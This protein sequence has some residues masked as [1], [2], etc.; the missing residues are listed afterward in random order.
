[1]VI[2]KKTAG[3]LGPLLLLFTASSASAQNVSTY[4]NPAVPTGT[5]VP[6]NY[7]GGLRPQVHF[8]PPQHFMN[9]P[10][11][12]FVDANG[13]WHLYYQYNPTGL[14]AGNQHWGHATSQD[15]YHW[16]N[17]QIALF[18]PEEYV[19]V[20]SGSAVVDVNNTSGFFP[21]QDNGVV[22]MMTLAR[23]YEDGSAGPQVQGI[24]YSHDGGYTFQYY[25]GNPVINSTSSQFRDP[26]VIWYE[27]HW[28][29]VVSYA[30]EFVVGIYTS[31]DLKN[32]TH[33]SNFSHHGLLGAQYECPNLAKLPIRDTIGGS[34][35]S[36]EAYVMAISV[37][38]GAPLG[39]S[40]TQYFPGT[41][42]GTHFEP[43]DSAT[44]L[45]DFAKD[46]YAAQFFYGTP[47]GSDAVS[48]GWASNWQYTQ[49]VPTG[50]L[51]GWRSAATL[52][53]AH[54]L[55]NATRIGWVMASQLVDPSPVL[56]GAP[57]NTTTFE[58]N[59][60]IAVDYASVSSGA[61]YIDANVTGLNASTITGSST[62]NISFTSPSSG[63]VLRS[64]FFF[65]GDQPYFIDRGLIRGFDNVFFTDKFSVADVWN[66]TSGSWRVQ[67]VI[68]RS[69]LEVYLD[70]GVH[71][72][73]VLFF[74]NEPL[75]LMSFATAGLPAGV[76][77]SVAVWAL[78]SAWA[79]YEDEQGTVVGNVTDTTGTAARR[80]MVY[81]ATWTV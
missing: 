1:M 47:D 75:T 76:E 70:G 22:A 48:I 10:N 42:N 20:F 67:A 39:G 27:D 23:Y 81:E 3:L 63:E 28:A 16:E 33:A 56:L 34:V 74:P 46:N 21:D 17:Q 51:E 61:L 54:Y 71:A 73:T 14:A 50:N 40:I 12:M 44:R 41:F 55:T 68:D 2:M 62:L 29:M 78:E 49:T 30:Q 8:S 38:P 57:L 69:V 4:V 45:T 43:L 32:W 31:P 18:P 5:P 79:A 25:D 13:T 36:D 65:G 53:R 37:Q 11:G 72:A 9:D 64:G 15:L 19:Y 77:V 24:A 59:A 60:S 80:D 58:G 52:P 6:G 66:T 35:V 26:K 7:T